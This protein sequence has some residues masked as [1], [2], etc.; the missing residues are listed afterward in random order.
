MHAV[1]C[2]Q[3][4]VEHDFEDRMGTVEVLY[5][6]PYVLPTLVGAVTVF[7]YFQKPMNNICIMGS[8][9]RG[10]DSRVLLRNPRDLASLGPN[11]S[12]R[13]LFALSVSNPYLSMRNQKTHKSG[14][15][16]FYGGGVGIRVSCFATHETSLRS[17]QTAPLGRCLPSRFRIPL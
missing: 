5:T 15:S 4:Q 13:S 10:R 17:D 1:F 2:H 12:P 8:W 16:D 9:R 3:R 7:E 11:S 6:I 14:S